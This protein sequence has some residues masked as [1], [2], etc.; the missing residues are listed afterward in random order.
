MTACLDHWYLD[1]FHYHDAT[2][3]Q[4]RAVTVHE[5]RL[6]K[7][8]QVSHFR[9]PP[10]PETKNDAKNAAPKLPIH[11]FRFPSWHYC[12]KCGWMNQQKLTADEFFTCQNAQCD[13]KDR[14]KLIHV[15]FA[16][17]C[18]A[19]HLQDF[20]WREW[21]HRT[22]MPTCDGKLFFRSSGGGSLNDIRIKCECGQK[23]SLGGIMGGSYSTAG[24]AVPWSALSSKLLSQ[25]DDG[26]G[27]PDGGTPKY[28]CSGGMVWMGLERTTPCDHPLRAILTNSTNVHYAKIA[29]ALW[30]PPAQVSTSLDECRRVLD[31]VNF[32][33]RIRLHK[34][35]NANIV[36]IIEDLKTWKPDQVN[37]F[38]DATLREAIEYGSG[39]HQQMAGGMQNQNQDEFV[40]KEPEYAQLQQEHAAQTSTDDLVVRLVPPDDIE[41]AFTGELAG[42]LDGISIVE[43]IR[44]TK[45]MYGFSRLVAETPVGS[46]PPQHML[47]KEMPHDQGE[48]WLPASITYG[49][50][51]FLKL[52]QKKLTDW[53][54]RE[55]VKAHIAALK[56]RYLKVSTDSGRRAIE[57]SPRLIMIHTLAHLLMK[58]LTFECGY[59]SSSLR[60]RLYV[61]DDAKTT[62]MGGL[63]IYTAS[64]DAEGSLGGLVRQGHPSNLA[65]LLRASIQDAMWCSSDPVCTES[66]ND[67]GQGTD[68][69]NIAAC[70]CCTLM[71]ETSCEQFNRLLDRQLVAGDRK[72]GFFDL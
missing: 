65:G 6:E 21:V 34:S 35:L 60:E 23:R 39:D 70:H 51:I 47:W 25:H 28:K 22:E 67:G 8:L 46:P 17:A 18:D 49:E 72:V 32:R 61:C 57:I 37:Q 71:P 26:T 12:R 5:H 9:L 1:E 68:G 20:P 55:N 59:G 33:Q 31:Q 52:S 2:L 24:D 48:K 41:N 16:A 50:G 36:R 29:S 38:P 4:I 44:E 53:E 10:G 30:I 15:R 7:I 3:D 69:L 13:H 11:L 56:A 45:V 64:G 27:G 19:G 58:R 62:L 43:K 63:L 66:G 42:K 40:I 54:S 14:E